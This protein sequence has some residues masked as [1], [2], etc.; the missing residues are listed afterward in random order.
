MEMKEDLDNEIL[1]KS[2]FTWLTLLLR[3]VRYYLWIL[4]LFSWTLHWFKSSFY[5]ISHAN[6]TTV[7]VLFL[8]IYSLECLWSEDQVQKDLGL[9]SS[10][11]YTCYSI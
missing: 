1:N 4:S 10:G 8:K 3:Y 7:P 9:Q 2:I 11:V 5:P 6:A